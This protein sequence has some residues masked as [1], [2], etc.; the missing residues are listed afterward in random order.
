MSA[1]KPQHKSF[2]E[3]VLAEVGDSAS[4]LAGVTTLP[5]SKLQP[6]A[7][8]PRRYFHPQHLEALKQ[9]ILANGVL[10]PL[11]VRP[12]GGDSYQIVAGERR[13]RAA[14]LAGLSEV[15]VVVREMDEALAMRFAL[16]ENLLREDLN[17]VEETE[18]VIAL[19]AQELNLDADQVV[20]LLYRLHN[21]VRGKVK[22]THNVMGKPS[23]REPS[24]HNVMGKTGPDPESTHNVMGNYLAKVEQVFGELADMRWTSFVTN[25][26]PLLKLPSDVLEAVREGKIEY[27]KARLIARLPSAKDRREFLSMAQEGLSLAAI[28]KAQTPPVADLTWRGRLQRIL[29]RASDPSFKPQD[30]EGFERALEALE[31]ALGGSVT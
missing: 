13:Y 10:Q 26:L 31:G 6:M 15:P 12:L 16:V 9:S 20:P 7:N 2:F 22:S 11:L 19:L 23:G 18:G 1:K 3:S 28:K 4:D 14:A 21:E 5:L 24:T 17:P 8:Q 25:R 30:I 27:T 29:Q